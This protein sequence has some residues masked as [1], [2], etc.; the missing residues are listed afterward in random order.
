MIDLVVH[1]IFDYPAAAISIASGFNAI[2]DIPKVD[3]ALRRA[4]PI[5][6]RLRRVI[7]IELATGR[8][9]PLAGKRLHDPPASP[10]TQPHSAATGSLAVTLRVESGAVSSNGAGSIDTISKLAVACSVLSVT[11]SP[12][13]WPSNA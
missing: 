3:R 7:N 11:N 9:R 2:A 6:E 4:M 10:N 1:T 8:V 13:L 12:D 5:I